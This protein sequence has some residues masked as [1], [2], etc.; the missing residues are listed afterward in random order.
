M[1]LP[2]SVSLLAMQPRRD[3]T[4]RFESCRDT[5]E[6]PPL[7][8]RGEGFAVIDPAARYN[9]DIY[10]VGEHSGEEGSWTSEATDLTPRQLIHKWRELRERT[11]DTHS[12]YI[13]RTNPCVS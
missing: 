5:L 6:V 9:V 13:E 8:G 10:D 11:Y 4:C 2:T 7:A 12:I 3:P 1:R